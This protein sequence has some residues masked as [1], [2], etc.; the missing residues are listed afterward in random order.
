MKSRTE[1]FQN[2]VPIGDS[3]YDPPKDMINA[4]DNETPSYKLK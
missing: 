4:F 3:Y 1:T 2:P